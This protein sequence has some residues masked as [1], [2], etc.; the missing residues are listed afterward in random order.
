M[1]LNAYVAH[2]PQS[3]NAMTLNRA[4]KTVFYEIL[5]GH[6]LN[7]RLKMQIHDEIVGQYRIGHE[8][9]S[10]LVAEAMVFP[11]PVTDPFGITRELT[12]PV[13][14]NKGAI[15]WSELK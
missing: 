4:F 9:I 12:V 6:Y 15:R 10:G 5:P 3:L 2:P 13:A 14:V 7:F 11:V 1:D 8:Y